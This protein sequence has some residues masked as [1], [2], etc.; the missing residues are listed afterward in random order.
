MQHIKQLLKDNNL[1]QRNLASHLG[2]SPASVN[3]ILNH[4]QYPTTP[5]KSVIIGG[6]NK[7]FTD[8]GIKF[9]HKP[10]APASRHTTLTEEI[11]MYI[12]AKGLTY[13]AKKQFGLFN[14]P[15]NQDVTS[16]KQMFK[17]DSIKHIKMEMIDAAKNSGFK[18][19]IGEVGS[20]KTII[21]EDFIDYVETTEQPF[22][23][24]QPNINNSADTNTKSG[25]ILKA[26]DIEE[27]ILNELAPLE[28]PKRSTQ[29]RANQIKELLSNSYQAG[30]RH[31]LIIE[32][33]HSLATQTLRHLKRF[34]E[35]KLGRSRLLGIVL[36]GQPE[37]QHKLSPKQ[38][39][40]RE[41]VQRCEVIKLEPLHPNDIASYLNTKLQN[42][43]VSLSKIID[44]SGIDAIVRRLI[45]KQND[46][47]NSSVI[48]MLYPLAINNL[49]TK[50]MNK[51]A[52]LGVPVINADLIMNV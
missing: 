32:E 30:N 36:I 11:D 24:I 9:Q 29:A 2:L 22:I 35:T 21:R 46:N 40:V 10:D 6:I 51:A 7:F 17:N 28:R 12:E 25:K 4:N 39:E 43:N 31:L 48:S 23:I 38:H 20:G 34:H 52:E 45:F 1:S 44:Q 49:M 13:Q 19:I 41:I 37:L 8:H 27:A 16:D 5:S 33:A 42:S 50:A 14:N 26:Q 47:K 15:F 3:L 18:A